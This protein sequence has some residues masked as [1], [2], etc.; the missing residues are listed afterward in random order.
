VIPLEEMVRLASGRSNCQKLQS[1]NDQERKQ[2]TPALRWKSGHELSSMRLEGN[3][4]KSL[5]LKNI[6]T[7]AVIHPSGDV[8]RTVLHFARKE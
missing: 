4:A 6:R 3:P 1:A 2:P 7:P 5:K 8:G